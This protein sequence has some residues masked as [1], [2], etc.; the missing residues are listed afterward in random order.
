MIES[1]VTV[2]KLYLS[3]NFFSFK[4]SV[5]GWQSTEDNADTSAVHK[6]CGTTEMKG[7]DL[8]STPSNLIEGDK[9]YNTGL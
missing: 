2:Y 8:G 7:R 4:Y 3:L 9:Q 1:G 5:Y 6:Q